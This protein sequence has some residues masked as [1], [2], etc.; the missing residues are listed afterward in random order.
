M[1]TQTNRIFENRKPLINRIQ[2][3]SSSDVRIG[4][5]LSRLEQKLEEDSA[6][7]LNYDDIAF[8]LSDLRTQI[9]EITKDK[10]RSENIY[11]WLQLFVSGMTLVILTYLSSYIVMIQN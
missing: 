8:Q 10:T 6:S 11:F 9:E 7:S 2:K 3:E 1:E 4:Q 5:I